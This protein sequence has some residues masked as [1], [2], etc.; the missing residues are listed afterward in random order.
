MIVGM[1]AA[2]GSYAAGVLLLARVQVSI[3]PV[4][5]LA[6]A[7][8]L[9]PLTG[10]LLVATDAQKYV[11]YGRS[12]QP[13]LGPDASVYGPLWTL[14]SVPVARIG[15]GVF[16][17]RVLAAASALALV[18]L[19][20]MLA[21]RK[22]LAAAFVGWN[23]LVALHEAGGGHNDALMMVFV[24]GALVLARRGSPTLS[25]AAWAASVAV[26]WASVPFYFLWA[27]GERRGHRP[28]GVAGALVSGVVI[29]ATSF[30]VY[31]SGWLHVFSNLSYQSTRPTELGLRAW[32]DGLGIAHH[33]ALQLTWLAELIAFGIFAVAAWHGRLRLGLAAIV[34][35]LLTT[36]LNPWYAIWGISLAAADD[37]DRFGRILAVAVTG[38]VLGDVITTYVDVHP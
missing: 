7:I 15:D 32:L 24:L 36:R 12:P 33:L 5:A 21:V 38:Y 35:A 29:I 9:V 3:R 25:G 6:V 17:M 10:L 4:V 16:A 28:I 20:A 22:S 34:F 8:Q 2:V 14:I 37:D 1:F 31:G 18:A 23:P 13:Y 30:L 26:K 19:A 27:I 11:D